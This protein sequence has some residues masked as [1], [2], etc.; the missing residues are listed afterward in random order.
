MSDETRAE[1]VMGAKRLQSVPEAIAPNSIHV[2]W[3]ADDPHPDGTVGSWFIGAR[4]LAGDQATNPGS[5][6]FLTARGR[7]ITEALRRLT[8]SIDVVDC[9][10]FDLNL[11]PPPQWRR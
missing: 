9:F 5:V 10:A 11:P 4:G 6:Q 8:D 1:Q 3:M 2:W 7:S